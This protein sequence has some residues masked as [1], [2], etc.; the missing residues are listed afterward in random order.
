[1]KEQLTGWLVR[2]SY[3]NK[4]KIFEKK[5]RREGITWEHGYF[6]AELPESLFPNIKW[7][8]EPVKVSIIIETEDS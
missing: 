1:M 8:D 3:L 6:R 2:D 4:L 5:P 7:K